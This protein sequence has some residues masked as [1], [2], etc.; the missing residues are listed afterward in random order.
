MRRAAISLLLAAI[1]ALPARLDGAP[2]RVENLVATRVGREVR[3]LA[4]LSP[5]LPSDVERRLAS[6]LPTTTSWR[7]RLYRQIS[8]SNCLLNSTWGVDASG[9]WVSGGCRGEFALA[10]GWAVPVNT[11]GAS[12]VM[13][14]SKNGKR[15]VCPADT[16]L[17]VA[18]VRQTSD[19]PC[20][21]NSTWGFD[22]QGI[23]VTAGCRAEFILRR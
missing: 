10:E 15:M 22:S 20:I 9:I 7:V 16:R 14:E 12:R 6:G 1:V 8:E 17:G 5:G 4:A 19:A 3:V 11:S 2:P 18:V 23:W 13:C 21:L